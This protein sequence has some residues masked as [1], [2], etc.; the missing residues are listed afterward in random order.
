LIAELEALIV[1]LFQD[2]FNRFGWPGVA[3]LMAFENATGLTPSELFLGLAGWLLLANQGAPPTMILAGGL[4]TAL[5]STV[6]ASLTY[7]LVRLGGRPLVERIIRRLR[8]NPVYLAVVEQQ[9]NR[10]G[11]GLVL[12]GRLIPGV[13]ILVTIPAGLARMPFPRFLALTLAGTYIWC[14]SL[15]GAGFI[16]GHEWQILRERVGDYAPMLLAVLAGAI[17]LLTLAARSIK[18][19][20]E[21]SWLAVRGNK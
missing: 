17:I 18:R 1:S 6:G 19:R 9:L 14:T 7:W 3:G 5:G 10:W 2:L 21:A 11:P 4:Y 8:I 13:R 12:F 20:M 15:I 16:L